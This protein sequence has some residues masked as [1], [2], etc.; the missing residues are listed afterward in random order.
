MAIRSGES[1]A[2]T[3]LSG[4][5]RAGLLTAVGLFGKDTV[6]LLV[7]YAGLKTGGLAAEGGCC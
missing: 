2:G 3:G 4:G 6:G 1:A 5:L 7:G